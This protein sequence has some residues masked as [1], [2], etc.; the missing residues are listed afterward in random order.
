MRLTTTDLVAVIATDMPFAVPALR[1]LLAMPDDVDAVVP[2]ADGH[3]QPWR[4]STAHTRFVASTCAPGMSMRDL[5]AGLR[6]GCG[7]RSGAVRRH[8]YPRTWLMCEAD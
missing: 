2:R 8:R 3:L 1:Q 6:V 7:Q 4:P 5:L